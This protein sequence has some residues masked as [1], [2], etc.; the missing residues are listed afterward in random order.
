M[1]TICFDCFRASEVLFAFGVGT[2]LTPKVGSHSRNS[3][4]LRANEITGTFVLPRVYR[5]WY[6]FLL[7]TTQRG[8]SFRLGKIYPDWRTLSFDWQTRLPKWRNC[9]YT[10]LNA[11]SWRHTMQ[12]KT[13]TTWMNLGKKH[14]DDK[15]PRTWRDFLQLLFCF[16]NISLQLQVICGVNRINMES[17]STLPSFSD[18]GWG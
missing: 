7:F 1:A 15:T 18:F 14:F 10:T 13:V 16:Y 2:N 5:I 6:R 9:K 8:G 3:S 12:N 17:T 4:I 11:L